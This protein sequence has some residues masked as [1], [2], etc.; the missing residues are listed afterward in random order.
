MEERNKSNEEESS[1][2]DLNRSNEEE[3]TRLDLNRPTTMEV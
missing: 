2:L 1:G 3:A